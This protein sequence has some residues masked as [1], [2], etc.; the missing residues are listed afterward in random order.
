MPKRIPFREVPK[1]PLEAPLPDGDYGFI[2][3]QGSAVATRY[4][5]SVPNPFPWFASIVRFRDGLCEY[6]YSSSDPSSLLEEHDVCEVLVA[7]GISEAQ[8][9][10]LAAKL[11]KRNIELVTA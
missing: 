8:R 4:S 5:F 11:I 9:T 3:Y 10:S 1:K 6:P 2:C 7:A